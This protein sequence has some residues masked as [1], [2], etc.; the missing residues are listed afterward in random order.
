MESPHT[1]PLGIPHPIYTCAQ[2]IEKVGLFKKPHQ[3]WCEGLTYEGC[4]DI[5]VGKEERL[6]LLV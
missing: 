4:A 3:R 2:T 5:Y 1:T 6:A